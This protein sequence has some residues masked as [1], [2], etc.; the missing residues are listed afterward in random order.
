MWLLQIILFYLVNCDAPPT[1]ANTIPNIQINKES[2]YRIGTEV[3]YQCDIGF[4]S[5]NNQS[6]KIYCEE[7]KKWSELK[8]KC[9]S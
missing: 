4:I 6:N 1:I 5:I 9:E 2:I 7:T 8:F 3:E